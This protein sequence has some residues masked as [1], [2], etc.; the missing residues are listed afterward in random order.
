M[1]ATNDIFFPVHHGT[2]AFCGFDA[3]PPFGAYSAAHV[4]ELRPKFLQ[5]FKEYLEVCKHAVLCETR[6]VT[7]VR[8]S[9]YRKSTRMN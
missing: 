3:L 2:F 8:D 5:D 7:Y 9:M 4:A 1:G 6:V